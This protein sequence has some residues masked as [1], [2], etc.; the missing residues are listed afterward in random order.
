VELRISLANLDLRLKSLLTATPDEATPGVAA[1]KR[2]ERQVPCR[3]TTTEVEK[4]VGDYEAGSAVK[5][6]AQRF[7][8]SRQTVTNHL[9]RNG[10]KPSLRAL[11]DEAIE[12]ARIFYERDYRSLENIGKEF[13]VKAAT[14]HRALR[15]AGV[16]FRDTHGRPRQN[17][18]P[19]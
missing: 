15:R 12:R 17:S 6:L 14:I 4:L 5:E 3:L 18:L 8:V 1:R 16:V 7:G 9:K 19:S 10:F 11:D 13:G 2:T